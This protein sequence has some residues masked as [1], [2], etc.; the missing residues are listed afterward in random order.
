MNIEI[1]DIVLVN[2][3][4]YLIGIF[5]GVGLSI[6]YHNRGQLNHD[7]P[8]EITTTYPFTNISPAL[9]IQPASAPPPL[10]LQG[11]QIV[12]AT[13]QQTEIVIKNK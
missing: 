7:N 4:S 3:L 2:I 8:R 9:P 13:P 5:S 10:N 6:K 1:Y 12:E 11:A